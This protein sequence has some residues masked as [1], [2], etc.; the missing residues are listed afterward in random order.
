MIVIQFTTL[1]AFLRTVFHRAVNRLASR[2]LL[3]RSI[4]N[5]YVESTIRLISD[6]SRGSKSVS[7]SENA[8]LCCLFISFVCALMPHVRRDLCEY[9][10]T[11]AG[12]RYSGKDFLRSRTIGG[13]GAAFW[14]LVGR[15]FKLPVLV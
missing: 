3:V 5:V 6:T 10:L 11:G 2:P 7:R 9:V 4:I 13:P 1:G 8:H 14:S 15:V 12:S